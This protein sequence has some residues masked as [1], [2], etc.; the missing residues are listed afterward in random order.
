[1]AITKVYAV[2]NQLKRAV[3][4]AA[5]DEKTSLDNIIEYVA[6]PDKTEQRLFE[7][8][9]NCASVETAYDEMTATKK[10]FSKED[11]VLAY[12]YIQSFKPGEV[13]PELAHRIGVEFAEECFGDRFEVVI[14]THLDKG[15]LHNHIVVNSVSFADGG[16]L[17]STPESYYNIIRKTSDRLCKENELSVIEN[18]KYKGLHYAEWKAQKEGKPTIR[19]QMRAELDD[20]ITHSYTMKEFWRKLN[21]SGYVIHR[22]GENI[23]HTSIIP[24]FGKRAIRLDSL[25]DDYT[26][27]AMQQRIIAARYG[28]RTAPPS[29]IKKT[30]KVKGNIKNYPRKK[31]KGFIALYFHYLYLFG[32]IQKRKAPQKVS[33]FLR[34][35]LIKMERYQKQFHFLYE[36][37]IKTTQQLTEYQSEQENKI[38]DLTEQRKNLYSERKV[39]D[40]QKQEE[41]SEQISSLNEK[42]KAC[43]SDVRLCK[44]IFAD[45]ERIQAR[46]NQAQE[47][48]TQAVEQKE[49]KKN[50]HE[51][52]S[53]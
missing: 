36:H 47:L 46:Y 14:G 21:K 8:A 11:K 6:N 44:A 52:R 26:E 41:I 42:L 32:K 48:Q 38:N 12:H 35:E 49:V 43:R 4:Y 28:I 29:Q 22:K 45:S 3:E 15:H 7:S 53:R 50:E 2:R 25:G 1:M 23:K 19:G 9:I 31:L 17:R 51:R 10:K 39:A 18:P 24:P 27:E 16:K 20:I 33:F 34:D 5:N 40:E 13:T 30:Y 37:G